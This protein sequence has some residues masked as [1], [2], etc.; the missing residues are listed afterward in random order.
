MPDVNVERDLFVLAVWA[1]PAALA[2]AGVV[3]G[4]IARRVVL[5]R[6]ARAAERSAWKYDDVLVEAVK[7][8]LVLWFTLLGL[9]AAVRSLPLADRVDDIAGAILLIVGILSVT[10]ALARFVSGALRTGASEGTLPGVSLIANVA[11]ALVFALGILVILQTLGI[12]ITPVITALGVGGLAVGLALQ[13]TLANFFAGVRILAAGK[14]RPGDFVK[15]ESGEEGVVEDITWGQTT[16]RQPANNLVIVP[17]AKL[18]TA[19]TTNY[20]LPDAPQN[21]TVAVGVAYGSDLDQVER[22]ALEVARE[23]LRAVPEG[24]AEFEPALRFKELGESSV[25]CFVVLRARSYAERW[26]V[27]SEFIKRLHRRFAAEGIEIPFP[28]RTVVMKGPGGAA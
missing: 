23:T 3:A 27:T 1:A 12:S 15:L 11:R 20:A 8:P 28:V 13:D 5:P 24:V 10:W 14:V 7:G 21:F 19:I 22:V 2:A 6:I 16:I 18:A 25:N 26:S 4:L 9:R 17:N